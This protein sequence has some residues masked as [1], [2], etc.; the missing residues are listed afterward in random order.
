MGRVG[1]LRGTQMRFEWSWSFVIF[2]VFIQQVL[3]ICY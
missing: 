1:E 2:C 3:I